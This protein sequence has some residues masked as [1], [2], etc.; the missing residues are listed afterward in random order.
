MKTFTTE[1]IRNIAVVGHSKS[2]K[3]SLVEAILYE[4]GA[5]DR[6][7]R[8]EEGT[9]VSD[10]D[11]EEIKRQMSISSSLCA[12]A[13]G[14][15]KLN[16]VDC[17]GYVDFFAEAIHALW[18]TESAL[19]V[20]E[21]GGE[22]GVG[23]ERAWKI[24]AARGL[25]KLVFVNKLDK[26]NTS[27]ERTL[28]LVKERLS[29]AAAPL[30][31]P[32]VG[33]NGLEGVVDLL[34]MKAYM[35]GGKAVRP[36]DIPAEHLEAAREARAALVEEIASTDEVLMEKYFEDEDLPQSDVVAGLSKGVAEGK[37]VPVM[38]GSATSGVGV[39][40]LVNTLKE[41][42]P[43]PGTGE[44]EG[45]KPGEPDAAL[46]RSTSA[47]A[48][49]LASAF[50]SLIHPYQGKLVLVRV[51]S[52][53]IKQ[54]MTLLNTSRDIKEKLGEVFT[55][56]GKTQDK[57]EE[58]VAGDLVGVAKIA[59]SRT[60]D[61]LSEVSHAMV[62]P[63]PH[64]PEPMFSASVTVADRTD[65]DKLSAGL[66]RIME[67]DM[68]FR[69]FRDA[70]TDESI[71]SGVGRLHLEV[72]LSKLRSA[73]GVEVEMG[74]PKIPYRETVRATGTVHHRYKKQSGGR[75][76]FGD[77]HLRI[78]PRPTGAGFE[79]LDEIVGGAIPR[80]F[81][82]AVEKGVV[83][84]M[85]H[86]CLAGF[87]VVDVAVALF[88]GQYHNVDSSEFAFRR[89]ASMAFRKG[90]ETCSP[91]LLEPIVKIEVTVPDEHMGDIMGDLSQ[92][93]G[94][95][96]GTDSQSGYQTISATVPLAEV[97]T[98][99]ADLRSLTGGRASYTME[100]SHYEE[101]PAHLVE[102]ICT[103][104]GREIEEEE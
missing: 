27:F 26:E 89:A 5:I 67:E 29:P 37:L 74:K 88:D 38:A 93:R 33:A 21:S 7:G 57:L 50:R 100:P 44:I 95:V 80:Q 41:L 60:G 9:T 52:G 98:Y 68:A 85:A 47:D 18:V 79:Y 62:V 65:V 97:A 46:T 56:R 104:Y 58:A 51:W 71:I 19:F 13:A 99:E 49:A 23:A 48:P 82:P 87:P 86:G 84:A 70:E 61:T 81:I 34:T 94:R 36:T 32:I 35:G 14:D 101:V 31:F 39:A 59:N 10:F 28:D 69:F 77:V 4:T 103:E 55:L 76:Q 102:S 25:A 54:D 91:V 75:G 1:S 83:E 53:H 40:A 20:V 96:Q 90:M 11:D 72:V 2:G 73:T 63:A 12:I 30:G 8:V 64:V 3:T 45:H 66:Q 6:L 17:P 16:L 24:A 15:R 42:M 43:A 78:E 92:R 22:L